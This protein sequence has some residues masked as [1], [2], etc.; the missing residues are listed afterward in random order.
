MSEYQQKVSYEKENDFWKQNFYSENFRR[1]Q[2]L[3]ELYM[4]IVFVDEKLFCFL[5]EL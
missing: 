2:I 3:S 1:H 5:N 4:K